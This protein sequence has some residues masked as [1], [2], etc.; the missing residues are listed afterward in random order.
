MRYLG[1]KARLAK[2]F[3]PILDRALLEKDGKLLEPFVG[4]FNIVPALQNVSKSVC[5][6]IHEGLICLY[7]S[8]QEGTF[9]PPETLAEDEYKCLKQAN[10]KTNPLTAFAAFGCTFGAKEWGGYARDGKGKRNY[11]NET[12]NALLRILPHLSKVRFIARDF[13]DISPANCV[14]YCDPPYINTTKYKTNSFNAKEFYAWCE[15]AVQ[16][17]CI[18]FVSEFTAPEYWEIVWRKERKIAVS[19]KKTG[20]VKEERLYRVRGNAIGN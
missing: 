5:S 14:I 8:L 15:L 10:D 6:D 17:D 11:A 18:V 7:Q 13:L 12:R 3:A 4:G 1:G 19:G 16:N 20:L 2:Y 9:D